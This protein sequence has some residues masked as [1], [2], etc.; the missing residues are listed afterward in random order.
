MHLPYAMTICH[1]CIA[2]CQ[3]LA[4]Y[5]TFICAPHVHFQS[6]SETFEFTPCKVCL[7]M[8]TTPWRSVAVSHKQLQVPEHSL[9]YTRCKPWL[10]S[11]CRLS[12]CKKH[13]TWQHTTDISTCQQLAITQQLATI[14]V[15][16]CFH[17]YIEDAS[18]LLGILQ[19]IA[20]SSTES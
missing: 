7:E 4:Y 19:D 2:C 20:S 11:T 6:Q 15:M 18:L 1:A 13:A 17:Y 9:W 12:L 16:P 8:I 3:T 14:A 5:C 10:A